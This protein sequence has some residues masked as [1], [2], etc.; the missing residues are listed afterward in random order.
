MNCFLGQK[1]KKIYKDI[2]EFKELINKIKEIDN[3]LELDW[4]TGAGEDW[5]QFVKRGGGWQLYVC[6]TLKL[7]LHL[8]VEI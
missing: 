1:I 3:G 4:D 2:F 7:V 6:C 8:S 5:A